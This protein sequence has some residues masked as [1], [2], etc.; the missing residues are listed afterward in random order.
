MADA[1][2]ESRIYVFGTS[3][4]ETT[5]NYTGTPTEATFKKRFTKLNIQITINPGD[6]YTQDEIIRNREEFRDRHKDHDSM[7]KLRTNNHTVVSYLVGEDKTVSRVFTRTF[8][9]IFALLG[10]SLPYRWFVLLVSE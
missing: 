7:L 10:L 8:Y 3:N 2:R 9:Y 6:S 5:T 1:G 4:V